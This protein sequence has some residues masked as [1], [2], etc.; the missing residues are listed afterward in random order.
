MAKPYP[1]CTGK[2]K[3]RDIFRWRVFPDKLSLCPTI[4][5]PFWRISGR[6]F[7]KGT[8]AN[9]STVIIRI[10]NHQ[11]RPPKGGQPPPSVLS[12]LD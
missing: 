11:V 2:K 9:G 1:K 5:R 8:N 12:Y 7:L 6:R 3:N 10:D 4:D